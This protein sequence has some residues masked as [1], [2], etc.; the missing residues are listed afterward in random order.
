[1]PRRSAAEARSLRVARV[2]QDHR[3]RR[4]RQP[5]LGERL[6]Q[7]LDPV[8][9]ATRPGTIAR[10]TAMPGLRLAPRH[11]ALDGE[12]LLLARPHRGQAGT[13]PSETAGRREA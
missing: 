2:Q 12:W 1:M 9:P 4:V 6:P 7:G 10:L 11:R 13:R 8:R 5:A 3:T